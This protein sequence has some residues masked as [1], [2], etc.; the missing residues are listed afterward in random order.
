MQLTVRDRI[1]ITTQYKYKKQKPPEASFTTLYLLASCTPVC[2][3]LFSIL[4]VFIS[5]CFLNANG[6]PL[7]YS[8]GS[9]GCNPLFEK[10]WFRASFLYR[11]PTDITC[12]Q[13][14]S[15]V[16]HKLCVNSCWACTSLRVPASLS[17]KSLH[18]CGDGACK[19]FSVCE[20]TWN[21]GDPRK[22]VGV[23]RK[24]WVCW[25]DW[26]VDRSERASTLWSKNRCN[27]SR[28]RRRRERFYRPRKL[29]M[30][31]FF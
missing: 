5:F 28:R 16:K 26:W 4:C 27:F 25:E 31:I 6:G 15:T 19:P 9:L 13:P 20:A 1:Y 3:S 10:W 17:P 29:K 7:H 22:T 8:W 30:W 18:C 2:F 23:L 14:G 11:S 21:D 12:I 24:E